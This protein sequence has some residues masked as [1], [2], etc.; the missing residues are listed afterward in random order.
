MKALY[1]Q[2]D[3]SGRWTGNIR[4][5]DL[6]K[7]NAETAEYL[8]GEAGTVT[9]HNCRSI[10]GSAPNLTNRIRPLLLCAYSSADALPITNLTNGGLHS[11]VLFEEVGQVGAIRSP[12][13]ADAALTGQRSAT[14]PYSPISK[15]R[16]NDL[17][18]SY[19]RYIKEFCRL[20][21]N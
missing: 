21:P 17:S 14:N 1:D 20:V 5:S 10:H 4:N 9:V 7:I 3:E 15:K 6:S 16:E 13:S 18:A 12:P 8:F 2:Y 11:E 19:L